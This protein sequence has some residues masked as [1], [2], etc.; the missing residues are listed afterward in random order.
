MQDCPTGFL[1]MGVGDAISKDLSPRP[2]RAG[3]HHPGTIGRIQSR[4]EAAG[5]G[6][7]QFFLLTTDV[8][9]RRDKSEG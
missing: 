6:R 8:G 9:H 3:L 5:D 7:R 4:M 2:Y 1:G